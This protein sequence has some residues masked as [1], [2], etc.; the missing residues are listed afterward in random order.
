LRWFVLYQTAPGQQQSDD[1]LPHTA[2][3]KIVKE[4]FLEQLGQILLEKS[5]VRFI[6][7]DPEAERVIS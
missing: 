6:G 7:F 2:P 3:R 1:L 5:P 4:V